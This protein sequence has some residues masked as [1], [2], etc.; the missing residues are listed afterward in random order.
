MNHLQPCLPYGAHVHV[1]L[2][3]LNVVQVVLVA[4]LS[5]RER[6][7]GHRRSRARLNDNG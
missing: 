3:A 4:W 5:N 2:V 6:R 1:V 7:N